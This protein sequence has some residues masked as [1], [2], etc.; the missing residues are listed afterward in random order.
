MW[1][2]LPALETGGW[3]NELRDIGPANQRLATVIAK[4]AKRALASKNIRQIRSESLFR[5]VS[6]ES[7]DQRGGLKATSISWAK[8]NM[9]LGVINGLRQML[10]GR[11]RVWSRKISKLLA[12]QRKPQLRTACLRLEAVQARSLMPRWSAWFGPK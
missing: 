7:T 1:P 2:R 5:W 11:Y 12:L 3:E 4:S 9:Q 6:P 10:S 8:D